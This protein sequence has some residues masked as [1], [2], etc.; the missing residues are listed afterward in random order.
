MS[1]TVNIRNRNHNFIEKI[2]EFETYKEAEDYIKE[3]HVDID[4]SCEEFEIIEVEE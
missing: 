4:N 3:S 2:D 1:Y